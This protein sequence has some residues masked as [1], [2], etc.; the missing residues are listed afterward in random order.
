MT[1]GFPFLAAAFR[2]QIHRLR[3]TTGSTLHQFEAL[4]S[5]WIP[6]HRLAQQEDKEHSRDRRWNLRLVFWTFLWQVGQAGSSCREA[7]GQAQSVCRLSGRNA[8]PDE[9]SPYCQSRGKIPWSVCSRFT[10]NWSAKPKRVWQQRTFGVATPWSS[11][12]ARVA[13]VTLCDGAGPPAVV[14]A[15]NSIANDYQDQ[16][17]LL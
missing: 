16:A 1:P 15:A 7:I 17:V 6:C 13:F 5:A 9:S 8:P 10:T 2:I 3:T 14:F 12:M 4:F 11:S